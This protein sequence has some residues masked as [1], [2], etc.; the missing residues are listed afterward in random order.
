MGRRN[1]KE[2]GN[3]YGEWTPPCDRGPKL[4]SRHRFLE[5]TPH[6]PTHCYVVSYHPALGL[7]HTSALMCTSHISQTACNILRQSYV[8]QV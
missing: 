5:E 2:A 1:R 4:K 6:V 7:F 3:K 8:I